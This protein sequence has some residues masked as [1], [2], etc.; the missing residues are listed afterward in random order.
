M[1]PIILK[2]PKNEKST[3]YRI[4]GL[5]DVVQILIFLNFFVIYS[6]KLENLRRILS[7]LTCPCVQIYRHVH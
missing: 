2:Y 3:A 6:R 4:S 7:R 1:Q 5:S